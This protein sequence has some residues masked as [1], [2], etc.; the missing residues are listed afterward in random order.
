MYY[1]I[2]DIHGDLVRLMRLMKK[3]LSD[4]DT[5]GDV[6]IFLGDY[7]DR[8]PYSFEVVDYLV[9]LS[10]RMNIIF[11]KGNHEDM[12][13]RYIRGEGDETVYLCNGGESTI[14]SYKRHM[15]SFI[16]PE[17]HK[18][19]FDE[20]RLYYETDEFVTVHADSIRKRGIEGPEGGRPAV[21][22]G[23]LFTAD[24]RWEKR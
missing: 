9:G 8:G 23:R 14:R 12:M 18:R 22:Q 2:G 7:I 6:M 19:F 24:K 13:E 21:D 20:L 1:I 3:V 11:L 10:R 16:F 5:E 15:G 17:E 4:F